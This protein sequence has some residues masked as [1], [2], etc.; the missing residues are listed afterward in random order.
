[1]TSFIAEPLA[2]SP[3]KGVTPKA[4]ANMVNLEDCVQYL[5]E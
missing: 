1:V 5:N 2:L 4:A 3:T